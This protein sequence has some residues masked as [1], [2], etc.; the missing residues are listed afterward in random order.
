MIPENKRTYL[1]LAV[2][3]VFLSAYVF[4]F[5][6]ALAPYRDAGEMSSA[7]YTLG[8]AHPPGYPAYLFAARAFTGMVPGNHAYRM[9]LFSAVCGAATVSVFFL[10]IS[11]RFGLP[12]GFLG[13]LIFGLNATFWQVS[14]V[15]EM[16]SMNIMMAA[17]IF[18][19]SLRLAENYNR[20]EFY[21]LCLVYG[22]SAGN[23]MDIVLLGPAVLIFCVSGMR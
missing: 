5:T 18:L 23:R 22:F 14:G 15:S 16:Y 7:V 10:L 21:L 6:P 17:V 2:F 11:A 13:A 8:V 1:A 12:A 4:C 3:A 19:L 20:Q 9:N